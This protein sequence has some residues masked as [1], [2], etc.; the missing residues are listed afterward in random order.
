MAE[1]TS[2]LWKYVIAGHLTIDEAMSRLVDALE[3][4]EHRVPAT[5]LA[6]EALREAS[7]RRHAVYD[8]Y[9]AVLARREGVWS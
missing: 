7:A 2:G 5:E 6:A 9:Y 1:V 8:L 4:V 3:L